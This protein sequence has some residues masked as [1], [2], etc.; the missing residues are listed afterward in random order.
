MP[1][2]CRPTA[3]WRKTFEVTSNISWRCSGSIREQC[4]L[5]CEAARITESSLNGRESGV[6]CWPH[7]SQETCDGAAGLVINRTGE[8]LEIVNICGTSTGHI[9]EHA[10]H[11]R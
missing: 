5:R 3:P 2:W 7:Q 11:R 1:P 9:P 8:F 4:E 10:W 6:T